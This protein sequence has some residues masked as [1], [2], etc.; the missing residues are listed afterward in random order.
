MAN[1]KFTLNRAGMIE[2]AKSAGVQAELNKLA[3]QV[4][5]KANSDAKS[6]AEWLDD[7]QFKTDPYKASSKKLA[8]TAIGYVTTAT[9]VGAKNENMYK[10]LNNQNH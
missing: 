3:N 4:A 8:R 2:I 1:A 9:T 10:S 6:H 5:S 7:K